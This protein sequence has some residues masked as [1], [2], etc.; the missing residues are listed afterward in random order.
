MN[1]FESVGLFL[2]A[3]V[4]LPIVSYL[5]VKFGAAGWFKAKQRER[6][7]TNGKSK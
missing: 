4:G 6:K 3:F 2:M 1:F 5:V 7:N